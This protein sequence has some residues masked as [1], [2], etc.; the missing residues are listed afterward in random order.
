M[1]RRRARAVAPLLGVSVLLAGCTSPV[2][3]PEESEQSRADRARSGYLDLEEPAATRCVGD[4][5]AVEVEGDLRVP[6]DRTCR[7]E[8]TA[9]AGRVT[10]SRGASL[11]ATDARFGEGISAHGFDR[12]ELLAGRAEGRPRE[13]SYGNLPESSLVVDF[14]LDGGRDVVITEGPS[15]GHYYLL[16]NSGRVEVSGLY[17]DLGGVTCLGNTRRPVVRGISAETPGVL[18]GQCAGRRGFGQS[19]F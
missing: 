15:D 14:V 9:V 11:L 2:P 7:L 17:L 6:G 16:D 4:L 18:D 12:V 13:W 3:T 10:V 19:D 1:I 8:G 5:G